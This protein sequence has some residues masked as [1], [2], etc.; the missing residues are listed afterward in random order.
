[1]R[2]FGFR[3]DD[4]DFNRFARDIIEYPHLSDPEAKLRVA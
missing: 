4:E 1:M 2:R 3:D